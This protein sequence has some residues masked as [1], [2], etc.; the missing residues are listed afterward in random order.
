MD[1]SVM[2]QLRLEA[3]ELYPTLALLVTSLLHSPI[4]VEKLYVLMGCQDMLVKT[5]LVFESARALVTLEGVCVPVCAP[6]S[7][8]V[9]GRNQ[10]TTCWTGDFGK[11]F[12][13]VMNIQ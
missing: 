6:V 11:V 3:G 7:G 10:F 2:F 1:Q 5:P 13:V 12:P 8:H 4:C 9:V